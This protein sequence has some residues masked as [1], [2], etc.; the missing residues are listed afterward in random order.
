MDR[1]G[2]VAATVGF[3]ESDVVRERKRSYALRCIISIINYRREVHA[4]Y[5]PVSAA[6]FPSV[7]VSCVSRVIFFGV[8]TLGACMFNAFFYQ[9]AGV[10]GDPRCESIPNRFI[11]V[12]LVSAVGKTGVIIGLSKFLQKTLHHH[13]VPATEK[14]SIVQPG[15]ISRTHLGTY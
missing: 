14:Q 4:K 9:A 6:L 2:Y 11:Y 10:S 15:E 13:P 5:N 12:G 1:R 7:H 3:A 8:S